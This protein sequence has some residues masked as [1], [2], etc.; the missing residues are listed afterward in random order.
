MV[1]IYTLTIFLSAFLLFI[2][3]PM[4]SKLLLP[5]LG[6]NPSVWNA[7]MLF[8]QSILLLG[9]LYA[10][11]S[12]RFLGPKKQ[13][14]VHIALL[15]LSL[16]WLPIALK[17]DIGFSSSMYP[18][19]WITL[20]LFLSIGMP[21]IVL[22]SNAPLIQYWISNTKSKYASNPYFLYSA[23]NIGSLLALL[24]YPLVIEPALNLDH[25]AQYWS[26]LFYFFV[27]FVLCCITIMHRNFSFSAAH[28]QSDRDKASEKKPTFRTKTYWIALAFFPSSLM[29]GLTTYI[30]TDIAAIPLFWVI[31]LA[32]YLLTFIIAFS[33]YETPTNVALKLQLVL[34]PLVVFSMAYGMQSMYMSMFLHV[35]AF[36]VSA[37]VCHGLLS[38]NKPDPKHLTEF[39]VWIS[40]GGVL[41]GL[42]NTIV[43]PNIFD[44]ALEYKLAFVGCLLVRPILEGTIFNKKQLKLDLFIPIVFILAFISVQFLV[45]KFAFDLVKQAN[46]A[47]TRSFLSDLAITSGVF[48]VILMA[49]YAIIMFGVEVTYKRPLRLTLIVSSIFITS[50]AMNFFSG[51]KSDHVVYEH[52]NFFGITKVKKYENLISLSH[53]STNHGSQ[54][55]NPNHKTWLTTYYTPLK[56]ILRNISPDIKLSPYAVIGLGTGTS[57]CAG[58][59]G[60]TVDFYEIDPDMIW[61]SKDSGFFTYLKDCGTIPNIIMGDG[62]IE[63]S[64]APEKRYSAII[65]DAFSSD[66]IPV[67]LLTRE[68]IETY[69]SKLKDNGII[70]LHL[71]NR[72]LNL[73]PM[74]NA[75]A[76]ELG[77][78]AFPV[79]RHD[80]HNEYESS[81]VWL[82]LT[83][84]NSYLER[85]NKDGLSWKRTTP[86]DPPQPWTD[87][88]SNIIDLIY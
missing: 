35:I 18:V 10:H 55:K 52:R 51:K 24:A 58:A 75:L 72:Y 16:L 23:S 64:K 54:S 34:I 71:S 39:Y 33:K 15:A 25:Q 27:A 32:L 44:S 31:P 47:E 37:L 80:N 67:H 78:I 36:F 14:Y 30:T 74:A 76:N 1:L 60:Q 21:F 7:A 84:D 65:V 19:A 77:L 83:N 13:S 26:I 41:G 28:S 81:S 3:Q 87:N 46:D 56:P 53:G 69:S 29:L 57:A 73:A 6:G 48:F 12:S 22:S 49:F 66:S 62:R 59:K 63:I 4:M 70:A 82:I 17:S 68:A 86:Q 43:A 38:R 50:A 79:L 42:F 45:D 5:Q 88:Y 61:L 20:A 40:F 9:Y 2:I 11:F 85:A 8:F